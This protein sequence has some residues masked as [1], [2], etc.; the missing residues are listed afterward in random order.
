M[1]LTLTLPR[2]RAGRPGAPVDPARYD[3]RRAAL[4]A[5]LFPKLV[6]RFGE[7]APLRRLPG[8]VLRRRRSPETPRPPPARRSA[9]PSPDMSSR[10]SGAPTSRS[11]GRPSTGLLGPPASRPGQAPGTSTRPRESLPTWD[12]GPRRPRCT[13]DA[14]PM[15]VLRFGAQT[16]IRASSPHRRLRPSGAVPVQVPHQGR[17]RDPHDHRPRQPASLI[18]TSTDCTHQVRV[19]PCSPACANWLRYG[20]QPTTPAGLHPGYARPRRTIANTSASAADASSLQVLDRQDP[21]PAP[22]RPR[23]S[24]P[25]G[26]SSRR[27]RPTGHRPAGRQR[28]L[29]RPTAPLHVDRHTT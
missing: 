6:D 7:P 24:R 2:L 1:F 23:G 14:E 10:A 27:D 4:D 17:R 9:A 8:P 12:A 28:H 25:R 26:P 5:L 16:D 19:L 29:H 13:T 18:G 22:G 11:G 3:Y 15:H 20:I 21:H